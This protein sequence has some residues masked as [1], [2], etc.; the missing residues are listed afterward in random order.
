MPHIK[1]T[2]MKNL[3]TRFEA[4]NLKLEINETAITAKAERIKSRARITLPVFY[5]RFRTI[6]RMFEYCEQYVANLEK[7]EAEKQK[8]NEL[9]KAASKTFDHG[10]FEGQMFYTS[11]GYDQTNIDYYQ[12]VAFKGKSA[13]IRKIAAR[14][15]QSTGWAS[16]EVAPVKDAFIGEPM[17]KR[18]TPSVSY[19]GSISFHILMDSVAGHLMPVRDGETH[20]ESW[21]A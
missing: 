4:K 2:K 14:T 9:K 12:I 16:A 8:R 7:R 17:V 10:F 5:I 1:P 20:H 11:W 6:D 3:T 13:I 19:N 15:I 21:Y 18:I